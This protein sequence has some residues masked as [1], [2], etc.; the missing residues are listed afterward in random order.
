MYYVPKKPGINNRIPQQLKKQQQT[1][2]FTKLL[3][4][5]NI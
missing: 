2:T 3:D 4:T 5:L 1:H